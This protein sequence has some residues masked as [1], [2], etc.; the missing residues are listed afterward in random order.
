MASASASASARNIKK[1]LSDYESKGFITR[2]NKHKSQRIGNSLASPKEKTSSIQT[3]SGKKV[4]VSEDQLHTKG[5]LQGRKVSPKHFSK[6]EESSKYKKVIKQTVNLTTTL[7]TQVKHPNIFRYRKVRIIGVGSFSTVH[8][9]IDTRTQEI[10][11]IKTSCVGIDAFRAL[12]KEKNIYHKLT[13]SEPPTPGVLRLIDSYESQEST[14]TQ[15]MPYRAYN[16]VM[17]KCACSLQDLRLKRSGN[18]MSLDDTFIIAA[19]I[20]STTKNFAQRRPTLIH[21]D[22]KPDNILL[23]K[24]GMVIVSDFGLSDWGSPLKRAPDLVQSIWYRSPEVLFE[25]SFGVEADIWSVGCI[26]YEMYVG[27]PLF[28]E[29]PEEGRDN[30]SVIQSMA[31]R[32]VNHLGPI[33]S[34]LIPE[35]TLL[36]LT[37]KSPNLIETFP[38]LKFNL[39]PMFGYP[40]R[41]ELKKVQEKQEILRSLISSMLAYDPSQRI[42]T[43]DAHH[44]VQKV[45]QEL[46]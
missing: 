27:T 46:L 32:Y 40:I 34:R 35:E 7:N 24:K 23:N 20:L 37:K 30:Q 2:S 31:R 44:I 13:G 19:H 3:L 12:Q 1:K 29:E 6:I 5:T 45:L 21:A 10:V 42:S 41:K 8:E 11:A 22:L 16:I 36:E 25:K 4:Q 28:P 15:L 9:A 14:T 18:R 43:F 38:P 17:E 26:L 39:L 33:P